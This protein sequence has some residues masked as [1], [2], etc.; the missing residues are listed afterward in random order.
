MCLTLLEPRTSNTR[1]SCSAAISVS[2][3]VNFALLPKQRTISTNASYTQTELCQSS[4][5]AYLFHVCSRPWQVYSFRYDHHYE[6]QVSSWYYHTSAKDGVSRFQVAVTTYEGG[7][8]PSDLGYSPLGGVVSQCH[9][10]GK[11]PVSPKS[12][13]SFVNRNRIQLTMVAC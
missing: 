5:V 7:N 8:S 11:A 12:S 13:A 2:R 4:L 9:S 6:C 10:T 3:A 1:Q